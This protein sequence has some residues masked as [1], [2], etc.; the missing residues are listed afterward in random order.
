MSTAAADCSS[1]TAQRSLLSS[2]IIYPCLVTPQLNIFAGAGDAGNPEPHFPEGLTYRDG[3]IAPS[4]EEELLAHVRELPFKEFEFHGYQGKRRV[5]SY[6]WQYEFSGAGALR[7]AADIPDFLLEIRARAASFANLDPAAFQHVLAI[8]YGPGAGI[9]W[10]RDK[11][12]FGE[13]VG[14]S[15]LA[16]CVLRFRRKITTGI[17]SHSVSTQSPSQQTNRTG[18]SSDR[19]EAARNKSS[20]GDDRQVERATHKSQIGFNN[21]RQPRSTWERANLS[22]E[23][24]SAYHLTGPA[25]FEW[26]HS[27]LRVDALRYSITFRTLRDA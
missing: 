18:S 25:R 6:G 13:V 20:I 2:Q 11:P 14:V 7:K 4:F 15:L 27:I 8:E 23:P 19:I 16:D 9:G 12:V 26:E 21:D 3:L 5:V 22:A 17:A 1:P 10:H 24:R